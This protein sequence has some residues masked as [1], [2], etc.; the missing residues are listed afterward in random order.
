[1]KKLIREP[2]VHFLL[3]GA[4]LFGVY[5]VLNKNTAASREDIVVTTGQVENLAATFAKGLATPPDGGGIE[6]AD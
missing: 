1:M 6:G 2:L 4:A 3:L 5:S